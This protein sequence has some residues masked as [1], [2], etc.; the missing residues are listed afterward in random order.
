MGLGCLSFRGTSDLRFLPGNGE[1]RQVTFLRFTKIFEKDQED[2]F[3]CFRSQ[4]LHAVVEKAAL[5]DFCLG[6]A[7]PKCAMN[8]VSSIQSWTPGDY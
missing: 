2:R 5:R 6:P 1:A 7:C 8:T 4:K 3:R